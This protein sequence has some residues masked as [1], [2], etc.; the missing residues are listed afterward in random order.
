MIVVTNRCEIWIIKKSEHHGTDPFKPW[1]WGRLLRIPR[2]S[3]RSNQSILKEITLEYLL[4]ILMLKLK[5]QYF[6]H[7]MWRVDS[8]EKTLMLGKTGGGRR[9]GWQRMRC[10][11]GITDLMD[12]NLSKLW[13]VVEDRLISFRM[14]WLDSLQLDWLDSLQLNLRNSLKLKFCVT[15][16]SCLLKNHWLKTYVQH[17]YSDTQTPKLM[18]WAGA[19]WYSYLNQRH[20]SNLQTLCGPFIKHSCYYSLNNLYWNAAVVNTQRSSFSSYFPVVTSLCYPC[21]WRSHLGC[22]LRKLHDAVGWYRAYYAE[23]QCPWVRRWWL[24]DGHLQRIICLFY[25]FFFFNL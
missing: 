2:T 23:E 1:C 14:D 3:R 25:C 19:S 10:L 16:F 17:I 6:G 21:S 12:K 8:L 11:D 13:V 5:P 18:W 4:K 22:P 9:R 24:V 7:L 15:L 20:L